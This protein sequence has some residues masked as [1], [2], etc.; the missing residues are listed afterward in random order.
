MLDARPALE[1]LASLSSGA[2]ARPVTAVVAQAAVDPAPSASVELAGVSETG[3][4]IQSV[5]Y[6]SAALRGVGSFLVYLPP[7]FSFAAHRYPALYLLHGNNETAS[8][9][10]ELGLQQT[11]DRLTAERVIPP[12][13]G[14]MIQ[15]GPGAHNWR[16][17]GGHAYE[18][19]V[20][21]V[22]KLVDR[23]FPTLAERGAR[24]IAGYS[25]G[26]YGAMNIA[27]S[28]PDRFAVVESWLGFF[29]GLE[30]ELRSA[31]ATIAR[32]GLQAF[33]YGGASD[34]IVGSAEDPPF[35]AALRAADASATSAVYA[36]GHTLETLRA[37]LTHMLAFAGRA[38]ALAPG[39]R[40]PARP[41]R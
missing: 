30:G 37:H 21:E 33:V 23:M 14:V 8:S 26:G 16:D 2:P 31:R 18:S 39:E 32:S 28:H 27:L 22:Q 40:A 25:M 5:R 29:N 41:A 11:L 9:F 4:T 3:S 12:L 19:Y 38:L 17:K 13:I 1:R 6:A 20:L 35:A 15:S 34:A 7:G 10:L 36:G 24:A